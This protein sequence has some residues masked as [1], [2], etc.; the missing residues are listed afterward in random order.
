MTEEVFECAGDTCLTGSHDVLGECVYVGESE[1]YSYLADVH[2][3]G[4]AAGSMRVVCL[5]FVYGVEETGEDS[6]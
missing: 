6:L 5:A 4:C 2:D 3:I 1:G